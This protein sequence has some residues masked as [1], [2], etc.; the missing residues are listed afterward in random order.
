MAIAG[1]IAMTPRCIIFDESTAMLDPMGRKD[2]MNTIKR[3]NKEEG[4]AIDATQGRKTKAV[5]VM[6]NSQVVL[7]ALLPETIAA[8]AQAESTNGGNDDE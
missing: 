8:R 1:I 5:L 4:I 3:L 6:E 2:V 7:S